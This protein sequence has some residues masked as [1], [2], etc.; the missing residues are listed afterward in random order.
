[1]TRWRVW[2]LSTHD[3]RPTPR[4][5]QTSALTAS[6]AR[7]NVQTTNPLAHILGVQDA[8]VPLPE[9]GGPETPWEVTHG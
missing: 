5:C 3:R 9:D 6:G 4:Y 1:M 2:Y 8:S 7:L